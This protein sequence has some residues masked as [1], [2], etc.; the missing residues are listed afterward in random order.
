MSL[1]ERW[2]KCRK[3]GEWFRTKPMEELPEKERVY[4]SCRSDEMVQITIDAFND[5]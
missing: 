3:C 2:Y 5:K 1:R 4:G